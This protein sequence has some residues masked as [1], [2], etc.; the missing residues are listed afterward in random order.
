MDQLGLSLVGDSSQ[1]I[2][3]SKKQNMFVNIM[4][5]DVKKFIRDL[6]FT[7]SVALLHNNEQ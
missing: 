1:L 2:F 3:D 5:M 6:L 4:S 7:H